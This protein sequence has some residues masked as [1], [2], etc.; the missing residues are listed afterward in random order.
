MGI[1]SSIILAISLSPNVYFPG[2]LCSHDQTLVASD[3][4]VMVR[5][6]WGTGESH[7]YPGMCVF[8]PV[9]RQPFLEARCVLRRVVDGELN[10]LVREGLSFQP[11]LVPDLPAT[12]RGG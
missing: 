9:N 11:V 3:E 2:W 12:C 10:G 4:V 7:T 6:S 5:Y 1:T 8:V